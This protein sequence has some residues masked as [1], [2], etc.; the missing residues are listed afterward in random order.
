MAEETE[1]VQHPNR[2]KPES[3]RT[4]GIVAVLLIASAVLLL[5]LLWGGWSRFE[6]MKGAVVF[7]IAVYV[8][9]AFFVIRWNRGVL[10]VVS[11]LAILLIIFA[12][13]AA[14]SWFSRDAD[15]FT[16]SALPA[17]LMG[18]LTILLI[19]LQIVLIGFA[20]KGFQQGWNVEAGTRAYFES[21]GED[22][23]GESA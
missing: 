11:A 16:D 20:M 19:P 17:V 9:F 13:V 22:A 3:I 6:G 10:P 4:R 18:Y 15:G 7:F 12:A 8:L 5:V 2:D 14:P 1:Q 23:Q 21:T